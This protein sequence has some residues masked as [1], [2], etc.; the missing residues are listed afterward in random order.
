[1]PPTYW[2]RSAPPTTAA[3]A[4]RRSNGRRRA[5][6]IMMPCLFLP[7]APMAAHIPAGTQ[8][9]RRDDDG[10]E[11]VKDR[12]QARSAVQ[13]LAEFH[14]D[15][16]ERVAPPPRAQEGVDVE[17]HRRH[18]RDPRGQG[19]EGADDRKKP[20]HEHGDAAEAL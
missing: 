2:K 16:G 9:Q 5:C 1:M 17:F 19:D 7:R 15:M 8:E 20:A 4:R 14:A 6:A 18:A 13:L 12:S 3:L 11:A 10:V